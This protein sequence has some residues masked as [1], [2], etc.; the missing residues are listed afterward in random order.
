MDQWG[1]VVFSPCQ[2]NHIKTVFKQEP[3]AGVEVDHESYKTLCT[4][5]CSVIHIIFF[6]GGEYIICK[7]INIEGKVADWIN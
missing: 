5:L 4:V 6:H 3:L 7:R 2:M 1:E